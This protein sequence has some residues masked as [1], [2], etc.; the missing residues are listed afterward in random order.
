MVKQAPKAEQEKA[1]AKVHA[2]VVTE[3]TL[4][5]VDFVKVEKNLTSLGFF[6][7]SSKKIK[8]A[9]AKV[10][11]FT[12]VIDGKRVEAKVTIA[13]AALYGLPITADQD[14]YIALQ[15][16]IND[17][18]QELGEIG[19]PI[20]FST[21]ELLRLLGKRIRTGKNYD[22]VGE[23]L[24][25]M[26]STAIV[27]E[28]AVYYAGRKTW[29]TDT[30]HVFERS[31]S[32]GRELPD[33]TIAD[34]NYVWLSEWQIENINSN[35]F[36]AIDHDMYKR[37]KNHIAKALVPLLQIWLYASREAKSFEKRYDELCQ[38]LN[39]KQYLHRSKI[40]EKLGPGL[41]ELKHYHYITDWEIEQTSDE[42]AYKVI[43]YH[44]DKFHRDLQQRLDRKSK[45]QLKQL[46][47]NS[48]ANEEKSEQPADR[49]PIV[50]ELIK[51]GVTIEGAKKLI[52]TLLADQPVLDQLEWGD[53]LIA[54]R[55]R[56]GDGIK[57]PPGF[58]VYLI[59]NNVTVPENFLTSRKRQ[60]HEERRR[61]VETAQLQQF[62]L[63]DAYED[64]R[65]RK[66]DT[67][68][69]D[70]GSE[71]FRR[72]VGEK[73]AGFLQQFKYAATWE[74][75]MLEKVV[76]SAAR[77]EVAKR[78]SF[79]SFESFCHEQQE[80][81]PQTQDTETPTTQETGLN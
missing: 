42:K 37:L 5:A 10:I 32:F 76:V 50:S 33:G 22:D 51:R 9:K 36:L 75:E 58:Y 71:Q 43:F 56:S 11:S 78:A 39:I 62:A 17:L 38:L 81:A 60:M 18:K 2:V 64:Y 6:T 72:I 52:Q 27:S 8:N 35:H 21:A 49:H 44:G 1:T 3:N 70:M 48:S 61:Q 73:R 79:K 28:G 23:W 65:K 41:D 53:Q 57:N 26:T 40:E 47:L 66:I 68:I 16:I 74:P 12:R 54:D 46:A 67:L 34:K 30:F 24:K 15:K 29:A 19:N 31:V 59:K 7:P 20:R 55:T 45:P 13:P 69:A 4:P 14:K 25:R 77:S 80:S 63:E